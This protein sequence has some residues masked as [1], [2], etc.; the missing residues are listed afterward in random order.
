[1]FMQQPATTAINAGPK[2]FNE[3]YPILVFFPPVA[4][5]TNTN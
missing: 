5:F 1:V 2:H 3:I 4:L